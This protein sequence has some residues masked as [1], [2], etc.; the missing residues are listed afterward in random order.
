MKRPTSLPVLVQ[1]AALAVLAVRRPGSVTVT[2]HPPIAV[3]GL[4]RKALAREAE[5]AVRSAL[6]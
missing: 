4:D 1:V 5:A 3:G 6:R 2:W